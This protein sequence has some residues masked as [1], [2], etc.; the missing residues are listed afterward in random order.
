VRPKIP[1]GADETPQL[2]GLS[3]VIWLVI[4]GLLLIGAFL[5]WQQRLKE[6]GGS[7]LVDPSLF[8][9]RQLT[10]G[11]TVLALQYLIT[12]GMFFAMPLFLSIVLGLDAFETGVRM[13]PLSLALVVTAPAVPKLFPHLGP[14]QV[15]RA[16]LLAMLV[17]SLLLAGL[18]DQGAGAEITLVP[19]ILMGIGIGALASQLGNVIASSVGEKQRGEAG[20]LQYTAQNLGS[21]LGTALVGAVVIGA[22][23]SLL[24]QGVQNAPQLDATLKQSAST[25]LSSGVPFVSDAQLKTALAGTDLS[26]AEQEA[27]VDA[28]ADARLGAL[29]IGMIVIALFVL[30]T[31]FLARALP[32]E[33]LIP[34]DEPASEELLAAPARAP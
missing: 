12:M 2:L 30:L 25:E 8:S 27:I 21:S 4:G 23:G 29:R 28:N 15:A 17:A 33:P 10:G 24:L 16:G 6:R 32:T 1:D 26:P 9:N 14:R 18:L 20:G 34:E 3:A 31:L 22:L 7:P 13:L 19:F 11:L 5:W